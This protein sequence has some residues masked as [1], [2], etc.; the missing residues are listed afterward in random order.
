MYVYGKLWDVVA[1]AAEAENATILSG[2]PFA[3]TCLLW[4]W[5]RSW[6][7]DSSYF[8]RERQTEHGTKFVVVD[9]DFNEGVLQAGRNSIDR[10]G[11][12]SY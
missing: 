5:S 12:L 10:F 3:T 9:V 2:V 7:F 6:T 8:G 1:L 11:E 4:I